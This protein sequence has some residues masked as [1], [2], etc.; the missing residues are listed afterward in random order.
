MSCEKADGRDVYARA[1]RGCIKLPAVSCTQ[2]QEI[3]GK[4][5]KNLEQ[6]WKMNQRSM[7]LVILGAAGAI[8]GRGVTPTVGYPQAYS[9]THPP[10]GDPAGHLHFLLSV[11]TFCLR[12]PF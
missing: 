7:A 1:G 9:D 10:G 3:G 6:P 5:Y 4:K 8:Q 11:A 2:L 12:N